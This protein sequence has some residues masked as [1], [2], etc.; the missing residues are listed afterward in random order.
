MI[1]QPREPAGD[2]RSHTNV[3]GWLVAHSL[4]EIDGG[5]AKEM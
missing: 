4:S 1:D 5:G 2:F 3:Y